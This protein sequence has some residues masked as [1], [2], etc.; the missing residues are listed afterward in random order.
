MGSGSRQCS[1][2]GLSPLT[3]SWSAEHRH[4][5]LNPRTWCTAATWRPPGQKHTDPTGLPS[6]SLLTVPG[7]LTPAFP[8][9]TLGIT[10][11]CDRKKSTELFVRRKNSNEPVYQESGKSPQRHV[12]C[13]PLSIG[14][15]EDSWEKWRLDATQSSRSWS[16]LKNL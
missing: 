11:P 3:G 9:P 16:T 10:P 8:F 12:G 14:F 15:P 2:F 7:E 5:S 1:E 4:R 13:F 6:E